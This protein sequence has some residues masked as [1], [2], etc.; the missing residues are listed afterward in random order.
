MVNGGLVVTND[1]CI[2][3]NKCISVCSCVGACR[4]SEAEGR[5]RIDVDGSK[6]VACGACF[7]VCEHSAREFIDDTEE[8]FNALKKG[9]RISL[10]L[11][12]A[13]KANYP[14]EYEKVL[15][16]LKGLGVNRIISVSFGADITTWGYLN[17]IQKHN[18][19]GGISQPCP[20]VV[21]YIE[22]YIPE[23]IPKLFPVQSPMMCA[24]I[25]ARKVMGI[26]D[27]LAFISPC[28]AKK[29]EME[30][31]ANKGYI[32]YNVTFSHLMEYVKRHNIHGDLCSDEIEYGL[33]S[34][35]PMPGGLKE[36]VYWFLG[37]SVFIRQIEGEKHMY[38]FLEKN[39]DR[40]AKDKTPYLFIDALN[41]ADGCLCGT[42]I[43]PEISKTDDALYNVLKIREDV[44]K[45]SLASAWSKKLSPKQR[46]RKFNHQ[47]RNL[48]LNDY[49]R[50]YENL[51][52][53]CQ[54][55]IPSEEQKQAIFNSM[56]KTT[57]E[58]QHINC[59][60]CGYDSC[61]DM[62]TA[63][64]NGFNKKENC[65]YY[66]KNQVEEQRENAMM[67]ARENEE[68][69]EIVKKHGENIIITV[70]EIN[71]SFEVLHEAVDNMA[72]GN[73][74][75]AEESTEIAKHMHEITDFC[76]DL[77]K[78]MYEINDMIAELTH[79]NEDVVSIA[80][81]T[82]LLALNA[83]IEA[84]RAGEAGRGF[85]VVADEI[86]NLAT[87]SRDTASRSNASQGKILQY[88]SKIIEDSQNLMDITTDINLRV[89]SLAASTEQIAASAE[90]ILT[91]SDD[92]KDRLGT[93]VE[94]NKR[95]G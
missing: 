78:S 20:A 28:I 73:A 60:C 86:N 74:S 13:F 95:L 66:I 19:T 23:L 10:L 62:V 85:A 51:S 94:D 87:S 45:N 91:T 84:A 68:E 5:N 18:F 44:K 56:N 55:S 9:E 75:N 77:N 34:L 22:R 82:N 63:I 17:Y 54:N 83:S 11:A 53:Q 71:D 27:K 3:C 1:N 39:K 50:T 21:G 81:Q 29:L 89:D 32:Q 33:G 2:G 43:E 31:P 26:T 79:N 37:E 67:L 4:S 64:H 48:D 14:G 76:R 24:A 93:L 90:V 47:F 72:D 49:L 59:S 80:E 6:C 88:V 25:Y 35:Y 69:K 52:A 38:E 65:I 58:T 92:V 36:N 42:A 12:P 46:L 7:D 16:G 41:C 57:Y 30:E 61:E 40:I 15:G 70:N 8:F